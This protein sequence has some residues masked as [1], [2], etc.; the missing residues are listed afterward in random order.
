MFKKLLRQRLNRELSRAQDLGLVTV[1]EATD[2][3]EKTAAWD[4][5]AIIQLIMLIAELIM[6]FLNQD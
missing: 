5:M 4:W 3:Y 1:Q 6:E 2:I